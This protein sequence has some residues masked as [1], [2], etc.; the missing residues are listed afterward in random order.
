MFEKVLFAPGMFGS[1]FF[2]IPVL[3]TTARGTTLAV[4]DDRAELINDSP[5]HINKVLRRSFDSGEA[6]T[7]ME[8][9]VKLPGFAID[10]PGAIDT[11]VFEDEENNRI[12]MVYTLC[13]SH[14]G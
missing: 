13:P 1:A 6:W 5:N 7:E 3:F 14:V 12:W 8:Y 9:A 4:I 10:G 2:R 11:A